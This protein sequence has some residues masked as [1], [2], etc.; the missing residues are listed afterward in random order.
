MAKVVPVSWR[1][2]S[3]VNVPHLPKLL[4]IPRD[5]F[6]ECPR[7]RIFLTGR[8]HVPENIQRYFSKAVLIPISPNADNM[9]R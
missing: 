4:K 7:T 5:I 8:P 1:V 9:W 2:V 6:R 3:F